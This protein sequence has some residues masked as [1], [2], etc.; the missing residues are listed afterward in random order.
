MVVVKKDGRLDMAL[1]KLPIMCAFEL[2]GGQ[3]MPK[4]SNG[5]ISTIWYDTFR[6]QLKEWIKKIGL[7]E[8]LYST[9]SCRR[10][11]ATELKEIGTPDEVVMSG[12]RWQCLKT[13]QGYIDWNVDFAVR[14]AVIVSRMEATAED[15]R[16]C[17]GKRGKNVGGLLWE[18][19][20]LPQFVQR[21]LRGGASEPD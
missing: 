15:R 1:N 12:G 5:Q 7:D 3:W 19:S 8:T 6:Q 20:K 13:M 2:F 9:H 10:G 21:E 14:A 11:G 18:G 17:V 4:G 16:R